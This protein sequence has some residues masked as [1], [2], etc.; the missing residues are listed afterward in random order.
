M[1]YNEIRKNVD[2]G[3]NRRLSDKYEILNI[4]LKTLLD[5]RAK[6]REERNQL[7]D[8]RTCIKGL[9]DEAYST[10]RSSR[11]ENRKANDEYYTAVRE[12]REKR[13]EKECLEKIQYEADKHQKAARQ[14][15]ELASLPAF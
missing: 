15:L 14:E 6:Q 8:E 9:L 11:E 3:E 2:D 7:Y 12:A 13:K 4:E 10:L 1:I 5:D